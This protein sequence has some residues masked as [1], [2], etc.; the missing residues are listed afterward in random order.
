MTLLKRTN[1]K[2]TCFQWTPRTNKAHISQQGSSEDVHLIQV[3]LYTYSFVCAIHPPRLK[4]NFS[5]G[6]KIIY[7]QLMYPGF[8]LNVSFPVVVLREPQSLVRNLVQPVK[9]KTLIEE[10][11]TFIKRNR[12]V[13]KPRLHHARLLRHNGYSSVRIPTPLFELLVKYSQLRHAIS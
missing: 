4:H 11:R 7:G 2:G 13:V 8:L 1:S 3:G 12:I 6:N 5:C 9:K 10:T